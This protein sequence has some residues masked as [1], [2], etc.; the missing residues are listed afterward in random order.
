M[1]G[2]MLQAYTNVP[3]HCKC[4][5]ECTIWNLIC[6]FGAVNLLVSYFP[7]SDFV[8]AQYK[9]GHVFE[10]VVAV[11]ATALQARR[12]RQRR[13]WHLVWD[14]S[15][16]TVPMSHTTH[17]KSAVDAPAPRRRDVAHA[18][19]T[20]HTGQPHKCA[21]WLEEHGGCTHTEEKRHHAPHAAHTGQ[22]AIPWGSGEGRVGLAKSRSMQLAVCL[23]LHFEH[24]AKALAGGGREC[25]PVI[26]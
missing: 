25:G 12:V 22:P 21:G 17:I 13:I 23:T 3:T 11:I 18:P 2:L 8:L 7:T 19:H 10:F 15:A 1:F 5:P 9:F 4:M 6:A 26:V 14:R 20:M 16:P 24:A